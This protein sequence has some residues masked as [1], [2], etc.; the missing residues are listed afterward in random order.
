MDYST[1]L[2]LSLLENDERLM[3]MLVDHQ[4]RSPMEALHY[5]I[6]GIIVGVG[7]D[8]WSTSTVPCC[9]DAYTYTIDT[10]K[11]MMKMMTC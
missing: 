7:C 6:W 5:R 11:L 10:A 8:E 2:P 4:I 1:G 9:F 3:A